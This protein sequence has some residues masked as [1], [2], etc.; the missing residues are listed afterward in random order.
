[1]VISPTLEDLRDS[2]FIAQEAD[3]V[4]MLWRKT[5]RDD[6]GELIITNETLVSV[7][8]NRRTGETGNVKMVFKNGRFFEE[9]WKHKEEKEDW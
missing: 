7:Q 2:S 1:M 4:I 3:T 8:A 6:D 5:K 9:D